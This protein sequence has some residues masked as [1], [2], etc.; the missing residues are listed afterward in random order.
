MAAWLVASKVGPLAVEQVD[1]MVV[2]K[3]G[4]MAD[5][6]VVYLAA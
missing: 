2:S 3:V 1:E 4:K 6:K 5:K